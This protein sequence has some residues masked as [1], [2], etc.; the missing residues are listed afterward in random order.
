MEITLHFRRSRDRLIFTCP[1]MF[2][3]MPSIGE[4]LALNLSP[5]GCTVEGMQS[6]LNGSYMKLRLLLPDSTPSLRIE[7][8]AVRW[9]TGSHFGVEF[10]RVPGEDQRR[11]DRF[12]EDFR[13]MKTLPSR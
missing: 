10:L 11:L 13:V 5:Q 4:G 6:V 12:L 9:V 2:A 3:G 7:L 1:V 8:A